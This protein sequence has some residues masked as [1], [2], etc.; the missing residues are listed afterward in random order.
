MDS[1]ELREGD[2]EKSTGGVEL[3]STGTLRKEQEEER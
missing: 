2:R 1:I 3:H